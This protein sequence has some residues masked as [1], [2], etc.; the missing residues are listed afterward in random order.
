M[1]STYGECCLKC[2][3]YVP[4]LNI[5]RYNP[6]QVSKMKM[7]TIAGGPVK[8]GTMGD[9][10]PTKPEWWCGQYQAKIVKGQDNGEEETK[11]HP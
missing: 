1:V 2:R 4:N 9:F 5:C 3:F 11:K 6:P 10:P 7:Q 8:V